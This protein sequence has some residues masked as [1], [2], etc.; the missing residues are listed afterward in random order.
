MKTKKAKVIAVANHKG[1]V[2]K[3]TTTLTTARILASRGYKVLCVD[4]DAQANLTLSLLREDAEY[5]TV[6]DALRENT[7]LPV[8]NVFDNFDIVASSL[9]MSNLEISMMGMMEREHI[10][11]LKIEEFKDKYD[12]IFLDCPPAL[13]IFTMNG[14]VAADYVL[15]PLV[16]EVLAYKGITSLIMVISQISKRM[17]P[18][19]GVVGILLTMYEGNKSLTRSIEEALHDVYGELPFK[20]HIR[21]N[22]RVA[23]APAT[24]KSLLE[25]A[26]NSAAFQDY[27]TFVDEF[28]ERIEYG[29]K[30]AKTRRK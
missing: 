20:S 28:L 27:N 2:G 13:S 19:L 17:N 12:F 9:A 16:A 10:I 26:P 30:K 4:L 24:R 21:K 22:A 6:A 5:K 23:E 25:Y 18:G 15:I 1:G 14:L 29:E 11:E 3:T 8:I 7:S